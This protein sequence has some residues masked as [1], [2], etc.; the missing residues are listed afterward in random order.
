MY[1]LISNQYCDK[2]GFTPEEVM[3][4][5]EYYGLGEYYPILHEWY[6]GYKFGTAEIY[7]PWSILCYME[8][9]L[10]GN[11]QPRPYWSNTSSN[12]IIRELVEGADDETR[13]DLETLLDGSTIEKP[14][15]EDITYGDIYRSQDN[16]WNFL[17]FTGYLKAIKEQPEGNQIY[18]EMSIPNLEI[19]SVYENSI[20][21]WFDKKMERTD[22]SALIRALERRDCEAAEDFIN[23]QLMD[24]IS[25]FDYAESYYHSF[26]TGLLKGSGKYIVQSN[27]ESGDGRPDI[28]LKTANVRKV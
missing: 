13:K 24:T 6:D 17:F 11:F 18:L 15:H 12:S 3:H 16:L 8:D 26:M 27:R 28:V 1:S 4:M 7:N 10:S 19:A 14:I 2:F 25:Y 5:L 20:S 21:Y 22:K 9:A 23:R